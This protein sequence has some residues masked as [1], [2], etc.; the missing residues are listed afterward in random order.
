MQGRGLSF[1]VCQYIAFEVIRKQLLNATIINYYRE[2]LLVGALHHSEAC[3]RVNP[4]RRRQHPLCAPSG[5]WPRVAPQPSTNSGSPRRNRRKLTKDSNYH[6]VLAACILGSRNGYHV[7]SLICWKE[8][9]D[10]V[11]FV[12]PID[13][14]YCHRPHTYTKQLNTHISHG[15]LTPASRATY[16]LLGLIIQDWRCSF[17]AKTCFKSIRKNR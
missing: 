16:L 2:I 5:V 4:K 11:A 1:A 10:V 13:T 9:H 7:F 8:N 17:V 3:S 6:S 15:C 12:R 14:K